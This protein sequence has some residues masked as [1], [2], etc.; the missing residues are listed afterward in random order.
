MLLVNPNP[1]RNVNDATQTI[2]LGFLA[3][4]RARGAGP[5]LLPGSPSPGRG[6]R[7]AGESKGRP[8]DG[9]IATSL[10]CGL[11]L[12][13]V[14]K[15]ARA[16]LHRSRRSRPRRLSPGRASVDHPALC[17]DFGTIPGEQTW[18]TSGTSCA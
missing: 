14:G 12:F 2:A 18:L 15:T 5:D 16:D 9:Y 1:S 11:A 7:R 8:L 13:I 4:S 3:C 6:A 10:L 17:Q